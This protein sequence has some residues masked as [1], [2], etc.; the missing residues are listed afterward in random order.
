M[1]EVPVVEVP[2]EAVVRLAA[3]NPRVVAAPPVVG[4]VVRPLVVVT[5]RPVEAVAG[6]PVEPRS[7]FPRACPL[8]AAALVRVAGLGAGRCRRPDRTALRAGRVRVLVVVRRMTPS[9]A[10]GPVLVVGPR[11]VV[12]VA[13][14]DRVEAAL[15]VGLR[16]GRR[17]RRAPVVV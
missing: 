9:G 11:P 16:R 10:V 4:V 3:R 5:A 1:V 8:G 14:M 7:R 12:V 15:V 2:G 6:A 13:R 17:R